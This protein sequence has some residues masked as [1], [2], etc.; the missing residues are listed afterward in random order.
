M[1]PPL[2][3]NLEAIKTDV[4][5]FVRVQG[6]DSYYNSSLIDFFFDGKKPEKTQNKAWVKI[7]GAPQKIERELSQPNI[8]FRYELKDK[9][10]V[11]EKFPE[12]FPQ[13]Q[14]T[15]YDAENYCRVW[16]AEYSHLQSLYEEKSDLQPTILDVVTFDFKIIL[17]MDNIKEYGGFSYSVQRTKW[18]S[19]GF[20]MLTDKS[21]HHEL[22]DTILFPDIIL[23]A[24]TSKLTSKQ[25]YKIIRKYI[26]DNINSKYAHITSDYDFCFTVKKKIPL[27]EKTPYQADVSHWKSKKPKYETRYRENREI[28]IF[29][30]THDEEKYKGYIPIKPFE[31][32]NIEDLKYNIDSFLEELMKKINEPLIDCPH[33]KGKGVL[34]N[35]K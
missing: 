16:K 33:C 14:V 34:L 22:V 6:Q 30:M 12:V 20:E 29:E 8:N 11:S 7:T 13:E 10:L 19:E 24:R 35:D 31:G 25:T 5:Y 1:I 18:D 26:Q 4:G 9:S 2:H 32:K 3:L 28:E 23:P 17:E 27:T 15:N 21:I